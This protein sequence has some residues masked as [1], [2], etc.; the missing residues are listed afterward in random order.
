MIRSGIAEYLAG[1][2]NTDRWQANSPGGTERA[3]L[4]YV[5]VQPH[6][7][8]RC[9][10]DDR[11]LARFYQRIWPQN[12]GSKPLRGRGAPGKILCRSRFAP[13]MLRIGLT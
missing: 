2:M 12:H 13:T 10:V 6:N 4:V 3:N 11:V 8:Q 1:S 7:Y 5:I 9:V